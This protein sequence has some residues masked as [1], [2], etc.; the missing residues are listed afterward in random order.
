LHTGASAD[1]LNRSLESRAFTIGGDVFFAR[2]QYQ[3]GSGPGQA[4]LAHELTH[5][6]QQGAVSG[7]LCVQRA[8]VD[9]NGLLGRFDRDLSAST[10]DRKAAVAA[11]LALRDYNDFMATPLRAPKWK[12]ATARRGGTVA[13][14][15]HRGAEAEP[16]TGAAF[17]NRA[18]AL[19]D[20]LSDAI[21]KLIEHQ[22]KRGGRLG[23][24]RSSSRT[25]RRRS[26]GRPA[27]GT[28]TR[29]IR[30]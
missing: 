1:Q 21:G 12:A 9:A 11:R 29:R 15:G 30:V 27:S 3:P 23:S 13:L 18:H 22:T 17:Y 8:L 24:P 2:G 28:I 25:S 26:A 5:T 19:L 7:S 6:V 20:A 4:L 10:G 14:G 16:A